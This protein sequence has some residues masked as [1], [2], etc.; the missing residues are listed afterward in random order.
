[1]SI[2]ACVHF[3]TDVAG[4]FKGCI[5]KTVKKKKRIKNKSF[6]QEAALSQMSIYAQKKKK[7][8]IC[9][10]C[11]LQVGSRVTM[12]KSIIVVSHP[13]THPASSYSCFPVKITR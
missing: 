10:H 5:I 8:F 6:V 4:G 1:M 2:D 3:E 7:K 11:V 12:H 9:E 13:A